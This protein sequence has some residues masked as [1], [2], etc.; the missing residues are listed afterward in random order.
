MNI[1]FFL[2]K[3]INSLIPKSKNK[4]MF[5]S[6]P[7]F[8]DNAYYMFRY[9]KKKDI[10]EKEL[11]WLIYDKSVYKLLLEKGYQNIFYL[12]SIKGIYQYF[13]S[14]YIITSSSSLWQIKSPLQKQYDLWHGIPL[15]NI[16]CMGEKDTKPKRY[17]G[18]ITKRFATSQLTKALLS[19]SFDFNAL[20]IEVTGQPPTDVFFEEI[21][22]CL[23][24]VVNKNITDYNKVVIYMPTYRHG[25]KI[26]EGIQFN[27]NNIFRMQGY[28]HKKFLEFLKNEKILLLLKLHQYEEKLYKNIDLG[29]NIVW[30]DSKQMMKNDINIYDILK[31]TDMLITD[32]SSV[33][34]DYLLLDKPIIFVPLDLDT[35]KQNRGFELEPYEFWTP[36]DKVFNQTDLQNSIIN[37]TDYRQKREDIK[38]IMFT[39]TNNFASE[40]ILNVIWNKK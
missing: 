2:V 14:K 29:S 11:L 5:I 12:K 27:T 32:Y 19:A 4:V 26:E 3:F 13:R 1:V 24:K 33:F 28:E 25:Y 15:K 22:K 16:L 31:E 17:T 9:M 38:K 8:S 35:Y 30:I 37:N 40:R 6:R 39:H 21:E 34:F 18:N 7:D 20:K 36:G 23:S 10:T